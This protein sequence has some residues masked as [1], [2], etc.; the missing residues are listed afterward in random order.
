MAWKGPPPELKGSVLESPSASSRSTSRRVSVAFAWFEEVRVSSMCHTSRPQPGR[1]L[2][3]PV[4][5]RFSTRKYSPV[6]EATLN[7]QLM[8]PG[9]SPS[10]I[11]AWLV[12]ACS[13]VSVLV[14][15]TWRGVAQPSYDFE[16]ASGS[17]G[18]LPAKCPGSASQLP[19]DMMLQ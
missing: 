7:V 19:K 11:G 15:V 5:W 14:P 10:W 9:L 1:A 16:K 17:G 13:M 12:S 2:S 6:P 4:F 3:S 8:P 18:S